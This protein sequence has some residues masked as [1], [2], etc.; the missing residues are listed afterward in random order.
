M[1]FHQRIKLMVGELAAGKHTVFAKK[2]GIPPSTMQT[3]ITGT[4][5]PKADHL[6]KIVSAYRIN[7][8]WLLVG[9]GEPFSQEGG[10]AKT[11]EV[12]I[13]TN[14][15]ML[16]VEEAIQEAGVSV[17]ETQKQN[18]VS[19]IREEMKILAFRVVRALKHCTFFNP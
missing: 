16:L 6:A 17:T 11:P 19:I 4:S 12:G 8:N 2:C 13:F 1:D 14:D 3:Y 15:A 10:E 5:I 7:L 18:L 9:E